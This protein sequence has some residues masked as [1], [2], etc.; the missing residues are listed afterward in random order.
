MMS[1]ILP[2]LVAVMAFAAVANASSLR[3]QRITTVYEDYEAGFAYVHQCGDFQKLMTE[4]PLYMANAQIV[5]AAL[6]EQ[7]IAEGGVSMQ[8][9]QEMIFKR[10]DQIQQALGT[11]YKKEGC[12]SAT[13]QAGKRIVDSFS[14]ISPEKTADFL[15]EIEKN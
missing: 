10:K 8:R 5:V 14:Q 3:L 15:A 1:R 7:L 12:Q 4:K 6:A 13:A 11:V 9:A 2:V